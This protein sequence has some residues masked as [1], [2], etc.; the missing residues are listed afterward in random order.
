M[1]REGLIY[2]GREKNIE[3]A[4]NRTKVNEGV[5]IKES[6]RE[7]KDIIIV[8]PVGD[9]AYSKYTT[10]LKQNNGVLEATYTRSK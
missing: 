4:R 10:T 3:I 2:V 7:G 1:L 9:M 5:D 8:K 6:I